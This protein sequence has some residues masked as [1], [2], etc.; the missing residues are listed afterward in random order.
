MAPAASQKLN[1]DIRKLKEE[2]LKLAKKVIIKDVAFEINKIGGCDQTYMDGKIICVITVLSY[3]DLKLVEKKYTLKDA[4]LPYMEGYLF[5]GEGPVIIETYNKLE[6][7]PDLLMVDGSG[8]L[9]PRKIG[10]AS[11]LGLVLDVPT[12]GVTKNML[13]GELQG[14]KVLLNDE[15]RGQLVVT[16]QGGNPI[17]VS[18][19]HKMTL[20]KAVKLVKETVKAPYKMPDPVALAH[21]FANKLKKF[22]KGKESS[23]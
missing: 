3:P 13:C 20:K 2:Q 1:I 4:E 10:I 15:I 6:N 12:L 11:Q 18:P 7:K 23:V 16:K 21:K 19:G 14:D 8:I 9:H 5:Y 17:F 22:Q